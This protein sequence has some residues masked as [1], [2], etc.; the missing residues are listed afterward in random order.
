MVLEMMEGG[1]LFDRISKQKRFT[2]RKAARY[3]RKV[4]LSL[5]PFYTC[6]V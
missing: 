4:I 2:E 5:G 6:K 1:E 3:F